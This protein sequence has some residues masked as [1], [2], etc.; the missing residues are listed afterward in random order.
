MAVVVN[1]HSF[2]GTASKPSLTFWAFSTEWI[3]MELSVP[4]TRELMIETH[5]SSIPCNKHTSAWFKMCQQNAFTPELKWE[6]SVQ[7]CVS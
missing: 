2:G 5:F 7:V 6:P 4:A 1:H 3:V